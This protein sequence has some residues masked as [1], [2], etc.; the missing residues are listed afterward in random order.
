[1]LT[2]SIKFEYSWYSYGQNISGHSK[3]TA[4]RYGYLQIIV[5]EMKQWYH[6]TL[7]ITS[8]CIVRIMKGQDRLFGSQRVFFIGPTK[9]K[10]KA[11]MQTV[12][13][14]FIMSQ[15]PRMAILYIKNHIKSYD[16][17]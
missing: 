11:F 10:N 16:R 8:V 5:Y 6:E 3:L 14:V 17:L 2:S 1:M 7:L 15:N 9:Q 13:S 12:K 4:S